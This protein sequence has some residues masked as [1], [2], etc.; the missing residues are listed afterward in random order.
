[1]PDEEGQR[2]PDE[3]I[4]KQHQNYFNEASKMMMFR[5]QLGL[6]VVLLIALLMAGSDRANA[7]STLTAKQIR[8][9]IVGKWLT[10]KG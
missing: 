1:M 4:T 3:N 8:A 10:V 7:G 6:L 9:E 2:M 5:A